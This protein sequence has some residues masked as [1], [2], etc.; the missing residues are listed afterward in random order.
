MVQERG[1]FFHPMTCVAGDSVK[2]HHSDGRRAAKNYLMAR[3]GAALSPNRRQI[4]DGLGDRPEIERQ[5]AD[6]QV[7][8]TQAGNMTMNAAPGAHDNYVAALAMAWFGLM[9]CAGSLGPPRDVRW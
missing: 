1:F 7:E 6:Y 5:L 8:F 4:L 9:H 2:E 3:L